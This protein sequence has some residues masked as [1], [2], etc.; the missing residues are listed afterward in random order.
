MTRPQP[1]A[2]ADFDYRLPEDLIA[3]YPAEQRESSRLMVVDRWAE[4]VSHARFP[5]FLDHLREGDLVVGND[6]RV[7]PARLLG[8]KPSG[9]NAEVLLLARAGDGTD[10]RLWRALVRPGG[11]LKPGRLVEVSPDLAVEV[12]DSLA[13]G[14]RLVRLHTPLPVGEALERYGRVPLPPY[15]RREEE[16][17][18]RERYQ[19]VYAAYD[20]SVAAPTAGLHLTEAFLRRLTDRGVGWSTVTLHVGVATFRTVEAEDPAEHEMHSER[21]RISEETAEAVTR[22]RERGGRVWAV[23]TTVVRTLESAAVEGGRVA[24]G[25]GET[26]LFIRPPY[27]FRVVDGLLTNF[28]LPRSTLLMLVSAF[29][30]TPLVRRAYAE[31]VARE[32][33][34]FSYGDAMVLL[35]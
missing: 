24:P 9:A 32:Y 31:A 23:G 29:A 33:R 14:T 8:K 10:E 25:P 20:G 35:P 5:A 34:F 17:S 16:A 1:L 3:R 18:D 27:D 30:G 22:C 26:A 2:T 12:V 4:T 7:I 13:G 28:H 11:K 19:T 15:L 6:T 21:Y